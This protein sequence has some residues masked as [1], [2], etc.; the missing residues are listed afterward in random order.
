MLRGSDRPAP[1]WACCSAAAVVALSR[2]SLQR[3]SGRN[4]V[5]PRAL[6]H[7]QRSAAGR[8]CARERAAGRASTPG[9]TDPD[10]LFHARIRAALA[11]DLARATAKGNRFPVS[12]SLGP[13]SK[14]RLTLPAAGGC[15]APGARLAPDCFSTSDIVAAWAAEILR[16]CCPRQ[17]ARCRGVARGLPRLAA[18][19]W[20]RGSSHPPYSTLGWHRPPSER[21]STIVASAPIRAVRGQT[22]RPPLRL[23][24]MPP[25]PRVALPA[26]PPLSLVRTGGLIRTRPPGPQALYGDS[27]MRVFRLSSPASSGCAHRVEASALGAHLPTS[28]RCHFGVQRCPPGSPRKRDTSG[29]A[30]PS[31]RCSSRRGC[32]GV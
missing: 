13:F 22:R 8:N 24:S 27:R 23:L 11:L 19:R 5:V 25:S 14:S 12:R 17:P 4:F 31:T 28:P 3:V 18:P 7:A 32:A 16:C 15:A 30:L 10:V 2:P 26:L 29:R 1:G 20:I 9:T 6:Q 21:C